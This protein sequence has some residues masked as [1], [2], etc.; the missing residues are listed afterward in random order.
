MRDI[1]QFW[2]SHRSS[3]Q[4]GQIDGASCLTEQVEL[5]NNHF[6]NVASNLADNITRDLDNVS[7]NKQIVHPKLEREYVTIKLTL[8]AIEKPSD[9]SSGA[10]GGFTAIMFKQCKVP[11]SSVFT[12]LLN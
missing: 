11:T 6:A 5:F 1:R 9:S 12:C 10:L 7:Y 4:I 3:D 8:D 2:P